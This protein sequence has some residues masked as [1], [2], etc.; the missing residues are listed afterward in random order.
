MPS[1]S[2]LED[3]NTLT[4][5]LSTSW[6]NQSITFGVIPKMGTGAPVLHYASSWAAPDRRSFYS[7]GGLGA[8]IEPTNDSA[9]WQFT[10]DGRGNG[11]WTR[12]P[13]PADGAFRPTFRAGG[14]LSTAANGKGYFLGGVRTVDGNENPPLTA[15]PGLLTWDMAANRWTNDSAT[16]VAPW[17]AAMYGHME[18]VPNFGGQGVLLAFGGEGTDADLTFA[19]TMDRALGLDEIGVYDIAGR[20][21]YRQR[22]TGYT[23]D[24]IPSKRELFCSVGADGGSGSYEIFLYGGEAGNHYWSGPSMGQA[25]ANA[26]NIDKTGVHVLSLPSF[27]WF[28]ANDTSAA[29][30]MGHS[31]ETTG[32]RQMI[33]IGGYN[34]SGWINDAPWN[35][36]TSTYGIGVFDMTDLRWKESYDVHAGQYSSPDVVRQWSAANR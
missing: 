32:D 25:A 31:C 18:F 10:P 28:K 14:G 33:S 9:P 34:S 29:P 4:L 7:F 30:R 23:Q 19:G 3:N 13:E 1:Y 6:N 12:V 26:T 11:T 5:D 24:A 21:W 36:D 17:G 27:T 2:R 20:R 15:S 8:W 16:A 22:A 35:S